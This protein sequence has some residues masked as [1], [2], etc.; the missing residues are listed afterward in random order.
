LRNKMKDA[1]LSTNMII[2]IQGE[3]LKDYSYE[4][5]IA[6]FNDVKDRKGDF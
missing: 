3:L 2:H 5:I 6:D 1:F 4:D